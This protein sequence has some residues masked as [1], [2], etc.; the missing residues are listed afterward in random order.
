MTACHLYTLQEWNSVNEPIKSLKLSIMSNY[1]LRGNGASRA[2][3]CPKKV[4]IIQ[5]HSGLIVLTPFV[6]GRHCTKNLKKKKKKRK[7]PQ[8]SVMHQ[9]FWQQQ[10]HGLYCLHFDLAALSP[11][12][13]SPLLVIGRPLL[14]SGALKGRTKASSMFRLDNVSNR[15][16][17]WMTLHNTP[18]HEYQPARILGSFLFHNYSKKNEKRKPNQMRSGL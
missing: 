1:R 4:S 14:E 2:K 7:A 18:P 13:N 11:Q 6:A 16:S 10:A 12:Q 15:F 8:Q 9:C 17:A 5:N 3:K